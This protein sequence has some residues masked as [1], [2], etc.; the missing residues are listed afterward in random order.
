MS[1]LAVSRSLWL[2]DLDVG[3]RVQ[4]SLNPKP[5]LL[6]ERD[7]HRLHL[8]T[9]GTHVFWVLLRTGLVHV[10]RGTRNQGIQHS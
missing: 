7:T 2:R 4:G 6:N 10:A 3:V 1:Y 9:G 5:F 8:R